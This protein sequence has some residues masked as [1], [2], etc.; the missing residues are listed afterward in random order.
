MAWA[1]AGGKNLEVRTRAKVA[2]DLAMSLLRDIVVLGLDADAS[3][4]WNSD[5]VDRLS[6]AVPLYDLPLL[7]HVLGEMWESYADIEGYVDPG[8][9]V[10]NAAILI[11]S[12][13]SAT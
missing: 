13:R 1:G 3:R 2:L 8:L 10:E 11:R 9:A 4:V 12:A 7:T 6:A 5:L